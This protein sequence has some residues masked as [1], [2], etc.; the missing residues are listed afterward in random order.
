MKKRTTRLILHRETLRNLS[1][2]AGVVGGDPN[3]TSF[4][5]L[6]GTGCE[7]ASQ[8]PGC[9]LPQTADFGSCVCTVTC[10]SNCC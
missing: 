3:P 5:C 9:T 4:A 1:V 10:L 8:D 6:N 2:L 7:C